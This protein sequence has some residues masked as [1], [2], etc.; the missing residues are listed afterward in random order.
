MNQQLTRKFAYIALDEMRNKLTSYAKKPDAN[1]V[2][3]EKNKSYLD[4]IEK[5]IKELEQQT[6]D[7]KFNREFLIVTE[8]GNN[9]E[10]LRDALNKIKRLE[11]ILEMKGI[12]TIDQAFLM[13]DDKEIR[14][15]NSIS[16][17]K[18]T[19]NELY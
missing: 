15:Y 17:A 5:Y 12:N 10:R 16:Q 19:W 3:L 2:Y 8:E 6:T 13:R 7:L 9:G 18:Q 1:L 11:N 4:A 14:R